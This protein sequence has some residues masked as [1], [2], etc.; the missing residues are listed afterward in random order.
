MKEEKRKEEIIEENFRKWI[1][2]EEWFYKSLIQGNISLWNFNLFALEKPKYSYLAVCTDDDDIIKILVRWGYEIIDE[3]KG[4]TLL[5]KHTHT[6]THTHTMK[7]E[8]KT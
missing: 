6:H 5:R 2:N 7:N 1:D 8:L 3:Y 4:I